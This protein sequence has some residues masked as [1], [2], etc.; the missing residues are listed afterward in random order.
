[1]LAGIKNFPAQEIPR[2]LLTLVCWAVRFLI[3]GGAG[4][5]GLEAHYGRNAMD[6]TTGKIANLATL[7]SAMVAV[8]PPDDAFKSA[9]AAAQVPKAQLARY[10]LRALQLK[11]DGEQEPQYVPNDDASDINLEHILPKVPSD[12]WPG[13]D[14]DLFRANVNRLGN[15]V[16]LQATPNGF[17]ASSGYPTKKPVLQASAFS[18]T[19]E[20]AGFSDWTPNEIADRQRSLANLA[21]Q[22]W[23]LRP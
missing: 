13:M 8:V 5:G 11:V 2:F 17:L 16:L 18:L 23:P 1:L 21:V 19:K 7:A 10:Y 3:T 6:I 4:S 9:F 22:T 12:E 14:A 15:L 20:S